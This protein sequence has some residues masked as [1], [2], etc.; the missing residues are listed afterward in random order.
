M[1]YHI[2]SMSA[3]AACSATLQQSCQLGAHQARTLPNCLLC[4]H[5][6]APAIADEEAATEQPA[7]A[8][9][10]EGACADQTHSVA[11]HI[12]HTSAEA[13]AATAT[14]AEEAPCSSRVTSPVA[15]SPEPACATTAAEST[16]PA[17]PGGAE[18]DAQQQQE[19]Q[20][21]VCK[22]A[23]S[24]HAPA[25]AAAQVEQQR[26]PL[27]TTAPQAEAE[28]S[29]SAQP[30]TCSADVASHAINVV[31][32]QLPLAET[33]S[34]SVAQHSQQ[35]PEQRSCLPQQQAAVQQPEAPAGQQEPLAAAPGSA[36]PAK[37][38][39]AEQDADAAPVAEPEA[40]LQLQEA[41]E[42]LLSAEGSGVA[43][44]LPAED[45]GLEEQFAG[46]VPEPTLSLMPEASEEPVL[47]AD[48]D[49]GELPARCYPQV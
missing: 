33:S 36:Q 17:V 30:D 49:E 23:G 32:S 1:P 45:S 38:A 4:A 48:D 18:A 42:S 16:A 47:P 19:E 40:P 28:P 25:E 20:S 11:E 10:P 2:P 41:S 37:Q 35:Q 5:A 27:A 24:A 15:G 26:E 22:P 12:E 43:L 14:T 3:M 44:L 29:S 21:T 34:S 13:A 39:A 7:A 8:A 6:E 46:D 31:N 9:K